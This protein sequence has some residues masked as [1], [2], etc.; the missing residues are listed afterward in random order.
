MFGGDC[1]PQLESLVP[2]FPFSSLLH[3]LPLFPLTGFFY[4][5]HC[6]LEPSPISLIP[7]AKSPASCPMHPH[8]SFVAKEGRPHHRSLSSPPRGPGPEWSCCLPEPSPLASSGSSWRLSFHSNGASQ[9]VTVTDNGVLSS[10]TTKKYL[11]GSGPI[12]TEIIHS[13]T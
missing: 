3:A 8:C 7:I 10:S 6:P 5:D 2:T 11:W 4:Q 13:R 9:G 12:Q 1:K